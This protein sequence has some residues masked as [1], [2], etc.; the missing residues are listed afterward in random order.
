M[1]LLEVNYRGETRMIAES[2][3]TAFTTAFTHL[4]KGEE[5]NLVSFQFQDDDGKRWSVECPLAEWR[6]TVAAVDRMLAS[7]GLAIVD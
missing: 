1:Q 6:R 7:Y 3:G 5:V 4:L 2:G